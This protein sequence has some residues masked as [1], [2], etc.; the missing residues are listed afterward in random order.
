[1]NFKKFII[2]FFLLYFSTVVIASDNSVHSI[3]HVSEKIDKYITKANDALLKNNLIKARKYYYK[4]IKLDS[5]NSIAKERILSINKELE[6]QPNVSN[7][8]NEIK[9]HWKK[10]VNYFN[11]GDFVFAKD[12]F[13]KILEIEPMNM[14]VLQYLD[15]INEKIDKVNSLQIHNIF[16][17]GLAEF[18]E[19]NYEKALS[20]FNAVS[21]ADPSR[22]D[23]QDYIDKCNYKVN[24]INGALSYSTS[25]SRI[26]TISNKQIKEEMEE[27]YNKGLEQI[28]N[29]DYKATLKTFN[30]LKIMANKNKVYV[31]DEQIDNYIRLSKEEISNQLCE[32]AEMLE[33]EEQLQKAYKKYELAAKYNPLNKKAKL[34][35]EKL[36]TV[37][38]QK[39]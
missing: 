5:T 29:K 34:K 14:K 16:K 10:A 8:K 39:I 35:L 4:V 21:L 15:S 36:K 33:M 26:K 1:M 9:K 18:N 22:E 27:V 38:S 6:E 2:L 11:R 7:N 3:T 37:F 31:Y 17:Q 23:V 24:E 25:S 32:E 20:Y 19:G 30:R 28:S 12:E 13:N